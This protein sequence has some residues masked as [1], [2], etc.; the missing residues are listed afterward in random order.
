MHA[1]STTGLKKYIKEELLLEYNR[2]KTLKQHG[3]T[4]YDRAVSVSH[5]DEHAHPD[6]ITAG[7]YHAQDKHDKGKEHLLNHFEDADPTSNKQ[8]VQHIAR[9]YGKGGVKMEDIKSRMSPALEKFHDLTKR[10]IIPA[11]H[12]DLGRYKNLGQ[13][14]DV[15]DAH[16]DKMSGN[17]EDRAHHELMKSPEHSTHED[18]P[19]FTKVTPH[20]EEAAKHFGK[21]TRWCTA[22]ENGNMFHSYNDQG[23]MHIV[24]PKNPGY[25]GEKYQYHWSTESIMDETDSPVSHAELHKRHPE[26]GV[27]VKH[28]FQTLDSAADNPTIDHPEAKVRR[29]HAAHLATADELHQ[30]LEDKSN[31]VYHGVLR[32]PNFGDEHREKVRE[33]IKN[34]PW[35]SNDYYMQTANSQEIH[36]LFSGKHN[37]TDNNVKENAMAGAIFNNNFEGEHA[38]KHF[39][40]DNLRNND[41]ISRE[42][43]DKFVNS[44]KV[45]SGNV[46]DAI[47]NYTLDDTRNDKDDGKLR[48]Y[49]NQLRS[50]R[51]YKATLGYSTEAINTIESGKSQHPVFAKDYWEHHAGSN[52]INRALENPDKEVGAYHVA[53]AAGGNMNFNVDHLADSKA[54][55]SSEQHAFVSAKAAESRNASMLNKDDLDNMMKHKDHAPSIGEYVANQHDLSKS[56]LTGEHVKEFLDKHANDFHRVNIGMHAGLTKEHVHAVASHY[57]E[58][59]HFEKLERLID[60]HVE[61]GD[62]IKAIQNASKKNGVG[63]SSVHHKILD[64]K[65]KS[66][67]RARDSVQN[68][69]K[70]DN[71]MLKKYN[72]SNVIDNSESSIINEFNYQVNTR[73]NSNERF[74]KAK[75]TNTAKVR[76]KHNQ[77][78]KAMYHTSRALD[79]LRYGRSKN[80]DTNKDRMTGAYSSDTYTGTQRLRRLSTMRKNIGES[81]YIENKKAIHDMHAEV[82]KSLAGKERH[83][84][85]K[86]TDLHRAKKHAHASAVLDRLLASKKKK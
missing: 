21:G 22:A 80:K 72:P 8:Y 16:A 37:I 43:L 36:D 70:E 45:T 30:H 24:T 35:Y 40:I 79:A 74:V 34:H 84:E 44:S 4:F 11:E 6:E 18:H 3:Q 73:G 85:L 86:V 58:H 51:I 61:D 82:G 25:A 13:L 68:E 32:N 47:K 9:M 67:D 49:V 14:E 75:I 33:R 20:T 55:F 10:K 46:V 27:H 26:M 41:N 15:V 28:H 71:S 77:K 62:K 50:S 76:Q 48:N 19:T 57:A 66:I 23:P 5:E 52:A 31:M 65:F 53:M 2:D 69:V 81:A 54:R 78:E 59:G 1:G 42:T 7:V 60:T 17:E 83:P 38:N 12:R 29:N 56:P 64:R 63:L 39:T